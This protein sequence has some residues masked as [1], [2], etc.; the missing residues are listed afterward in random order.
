MID[1]HKKIEI[2]YDSSRQY[3]GEMDYGYN[4]YLYEWQREDQV[5]LSEPEGAEYVTPE[6]NH[7]V[8]VGKFNDDY[9]P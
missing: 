9:T 1:K 3:S 8:D 4:V 5:Q 2:V 6:E 7:L